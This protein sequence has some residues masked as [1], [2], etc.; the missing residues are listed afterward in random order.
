MVFYCVIVLSVTFFIDLPSVI[1]L[2][3]VMLNVIALSGVLMCHCAECYIFIDLQSVITLRVIMLNV[4]ALSVVTLNVIVV[5]VTNAECHYSKCRFLECL[6][7]RF[8]VMAS[9][10][11]QVELID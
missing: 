8:L 9:L 1:T 4:I 5:T 7:A 10:G 3:V 6:I 2:I 11:S